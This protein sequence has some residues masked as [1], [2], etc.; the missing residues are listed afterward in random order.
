MNDRGKPIAFNG[1]L[2]DDPG[3]ADTYAGIPRGDNANILDVGKLIS[4]A[5]QRLS[6]PRG[7]SD[8]EKLMHR[9][10]RKIDYLREVAESLPPKSKTYFRKDEKGNLLPVTRATPKR[11]D[12]MSARQWRR[13]IRGNR[14]MEKSKPNPK[15]QIEVNEP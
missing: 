5:S 2:S 11:P 4:D 9:A 6:D 10:K 8:D 15:L 14:G 3:I 13:H 1:V 12:G 7:Q